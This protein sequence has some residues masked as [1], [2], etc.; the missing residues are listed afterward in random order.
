MRFHPPNGRK[1]T[2]VQLSPSSLLKLFGTEPPGQIALGRPSSG[3]PTFSLRNASAQ[4]R[5]AGRGSPP[6][7]G[8]RCA[9]TRAPAWSGPCRPRVAAAGHA[10]TPGGRRREGSGS[11]YLDQLLGG[12]PRARGGR[13]RR[14]RRLRRLRRRGLCL[15]VVVR[16]LQLVAGEER[17]VAGWVRGAQHGLKLRE[18]GLVL[19]GRRLGHGSQAGAHSQHPRSHGH[20][21]GGSG[22]WAQ[23]ERASHVAHAGS[24]L[25]ARHGAAGGGERAPGGPLSPQQARFSKARTKS[26][27]LPLATRKRRRPP[28]GHF[29]LPRP[30]RAPSLPRSP[31]P[32][33][34]LLPLQVSARKLRARVPAPRLLT[35]RPP[36]ILPNSGGAGPSGKIGSAPANPEATG[37]ARPKRLAYEEGEACQGPASAG[38][39]APLPGHELRA[40]SGRAVCTQLL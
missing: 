23:V 40:Q 20:S 35:G 1:T 29:L 16:V 38:R 39:T 5:R 24:G 25:R 31:A 19:R 9:P 18:H 8:P 36:L 15:R 26:Q 13:R 22:R 32:R 30:N 3:P 6:S 7:P 34:P 11:S 17:R 27:T 4:T 37:P 12:Q 21:R 14:L 2:K 10:R 28:G 33:S